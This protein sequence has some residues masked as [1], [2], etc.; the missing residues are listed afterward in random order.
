MSDL[1]EIVE[2]TPRRY[3]NPPIEHRFRK[4]VSGNPKGRPRKECALVCTKIGGKT[5]IG[6][7]D[8]VKSLAIE[9]AYPTIRIR[10][11]GRV[12]RFRLSRLS[13]AKSPS[14]R[15]MVML[16]RSQKASNRL[17]RKHSLND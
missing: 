2:E 10:E 14:P 1:E 12:R 3:R 7:E 16:V 4:G 5:A 8:R 17:D 15:R 9:E 13:F 11:A 6:F